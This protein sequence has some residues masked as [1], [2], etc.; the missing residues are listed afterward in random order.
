LGWPRPNASNDEANKWGD[1]DY[2][3]PKTKK[4]I[5]KIKKIFKKNKKS[6]T[7]LLMVFCSTVLD[8]V[9][10]NI[11]SHKKE[12]V[13]VVKEKLVTLIAAVYRQT[14]YQSMQHVLATR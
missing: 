8:T 14:W 5:K 9:I 13:H 6:R 7:L 1:L 12:S 3:V 10:H 4:N 11:Y 2:W